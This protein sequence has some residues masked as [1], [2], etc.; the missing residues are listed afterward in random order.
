MKE[1]QKIILKK[2]A[3]EESRRDKLYQNYKA[4]L[5]NH[6]EIKRDWDIKEWV[7]L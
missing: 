7:G 5:R 3:E 1:Y 4:D 6:P 2:E